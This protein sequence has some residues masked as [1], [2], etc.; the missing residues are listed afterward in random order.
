MTN[1]IIDKELFDIVT[2]GTYAELYEMKELI[3]DL[4]I[5]FQVSSHYGLRNWLEKYSG[6]RFK[7]FNNSN[8]Y[9][10]TFLLEDGRTFSHEEMM[11]Y[12]KEHFNV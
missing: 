4:H 7:R 10:N 11:N 3:N 6:L 12:L 2:G 9:Y 1:N 8:A 5:G